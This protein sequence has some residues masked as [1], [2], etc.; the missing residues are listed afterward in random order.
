MKEYP[1]AKTHE[2]LKKMYEKKALS[3]SFFTGLP[4][5]G[6]LHRCRKPC[7]YWI[8]LFHVHSKIIKKLRELVTSDRRST[9]RV[10]AN[11]LDIYKEEAWQ[12]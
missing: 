12:K 11:K 8:G 7:S 2:L 9:I 10:I 5:L 4:F 1:T 6:W 3:R